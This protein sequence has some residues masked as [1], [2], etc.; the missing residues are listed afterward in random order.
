M[1]GSSCK[2]NS[3]FKMKNFKEEKKVKTKSINFF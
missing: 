2:D 1:N 3:L